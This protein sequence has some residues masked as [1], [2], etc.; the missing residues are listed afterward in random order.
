MPFK[1]PL[2]RLGPMQTYLGGC[3][4]ELSGDEQLRLALDLAVRHWNRGTH[5]GG[6]RGH[7]YLYGSAAYDAWIEALGRFDTLSADEAKQLAHTN[8]WAGICGLA[9]ARV[10]GAAF[11]REHKALAPD[12]VAGHMQRAAESC[13]AAFTTLFPAHRNEKLFRM[14]WERPVAEWTAEQ[15]AREIDVLKQVRAHDERTIA[16]LEHALAALN[17]GKESPAK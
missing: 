12:E 10:A 1:L 2:D 13:T 3:E 6:L 17:A 4:S 16:E 7:V 5:D 9:D 15:R 14:P 8:G 11:L